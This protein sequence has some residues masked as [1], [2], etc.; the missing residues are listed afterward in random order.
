M[1]MERAQLDPVRQAKVK[2]AMVEQWEQDSFQERTNE[3]LEEPRN[4]SEKE[5]K[6]PRT[7]L[8]KELEEETGTDLKTEK[9]DPSTECDKVVLTEEPGSDLETE[10]NDPSM[11]CKKE[12]VDDP[13]IPGNGWETE[14]NGPSAEYAKEMVE[15]VG[16]ESFARP[17]FPALLWGVSIRC[18]SRHCDTCWRPMSL[19]M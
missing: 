2:A 18:S 10:A 13:Y 6:D 11:E 8:A 7:D 16:N 3:M 12:V 19:Q 4:D 5:A 1:E 17:A 9:S 15:E 14:A